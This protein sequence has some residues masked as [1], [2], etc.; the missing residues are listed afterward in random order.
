M[1]ALADQLGVGERMH[2]VGFQADVRPYI[3]AMNL[4]V[5]PSR[6]EGLPV[7]L[8]EAM[9]MGLPVIASAVGGIPE[10]IVQGVTGGLVESENTSALREAML[11][12]LSHPHRGI[13]EGKR[14]KE[15]V[16]RRYSIQAEIQA[17]EE[18]YHSVVSREAQCDGVSCV[19]R[20]KKTKA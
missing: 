9:A 16:H 1:H 13:P 6:S 11:D 4:V 3:A 5:L 14:G 10:L 15:R 17:L 12:Y 7:S 18:L 19:G 20:D 2:F 8:L